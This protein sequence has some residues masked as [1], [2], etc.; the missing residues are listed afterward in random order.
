MSWI[1]RSSLQSNSGRVNILSDLFKLSST[2][3]KGKYF[4]QYVQNSSFN[5]CT[6][7][8]SQEGKHCIQKGRCH[9]T[10]APDDEDIRYCTGCEH[11]YHASCL[12]DDVNY[13]HVVQ[14][15]AHP[16][17]M[18]L[19]NIEDFDPKYPTFEVLAR[20]PIVRRARPPTDVRRVQEDLEGT[21]YSPLSL[22]RI[23]AGAIEVTRSKAQNEHRDIWSW[24]ISV[25]KDKKKYK[26]KELIHIAVKA[27]LDELQ[28]ED[29]EVVE[30]LGTTFDVNRWYKCPTCVETA[31]L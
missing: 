30:R 21:F 28:E 25:Q 10:W 7:V 23:I 1:S 31:F 17:Q 4:Y 27:A 12:G 29:V 14:H 26:M 8:S 18:H 22:E 3:S 13:A 15:V 6:H 11:W 24:C 20:L 2:V 19:R 5:P 16:Q 9:K